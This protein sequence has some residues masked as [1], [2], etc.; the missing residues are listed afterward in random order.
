MNVEQGL[1]IVLHKKIAWS[2]WKRPGSESDLEGRNWLFVG[3]GL[4]HY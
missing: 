1:S 2:F 4:E 3:E